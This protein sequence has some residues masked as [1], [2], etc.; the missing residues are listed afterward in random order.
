MY[1][2]TDPTL[3]KDINMWKQ[4]DNRRNKTMSDWERDEWIEK[5]KQ[6]QKIREGDLNKAVPLRETKAEYDRIIGE[7]DHQSV[8]FPKRPLGSQVGAGVAG[9]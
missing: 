9:G 3:N 5:Y 4:S 2:E 1:L 8:Y 7:T 6:F